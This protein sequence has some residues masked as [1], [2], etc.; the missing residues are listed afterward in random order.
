[1]G[2]ARQAGSDLQGGAE[3]ETNEDGGSCVVVTSDIGG[4]GVGN[5]KLGGRAL[6]TNMK[7]ANVRAFNPTTLKLLTT[8]PA[9]K[10]AHNATFSPNGKLAFIATVG[11]NNVT[12]IDAVNKEALGDVPAGTR[13]HQVAIID[14][15]SH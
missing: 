14:T 6:V 10:G 1:V 12:I 5:R 4:R 9:D 3:D 15:A 8:I 11:A 7:P 13:A 2:F